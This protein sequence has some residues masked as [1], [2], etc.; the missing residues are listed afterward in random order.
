MLK[1]KKF[2]R[3]LATLSL[4]ELCGRYPVTAGVMTLLGVGGV[5]SGISP[6]SPPAI[7][8]QP[9]V[10]FT[11]SSAV[12]TITN[13]TLRPNG[14]TAGAEY[15]PSTIGN[16]VAY[17]VEGSVDP[18]ISTGSSY[19]YALGRAA[20]ANSLVVTSPGP[21]APQ[22]MVQSGIAG[23]LTPT[24]WWLSAGN[25][26]FGVATGITKGT[27]Y[28]EGYYPWT[29]TGGGCTREP[30]GYVWP[31]NTMAV[32]DPG[33]QCGYGAAA[34]SMV[35]I[36]GTG[37][38]QSTVP[39]TTCT[40]NSPFT[41]EFT[42]TASVA[43]AHGVLPGQ[44]FALTGFTPS[45]YNLTYTAIAGTAGTTLVGVNTSTGTCPGTVTGEGSAMS[46][47]GGSINLTALSTTTPFTSDNTTGITTRPG[48]HFCGVWGEYGQDSA[49]PGFQFASFTDR[50]GNALPGAP[51]VSTWPNQGTAS[52]TGYTITGAQGT[53]G[54]AL[55]VTAMISFPISAAVWNNSTSVTFTFSSNPGLWLG[56]EFTVSGSNPA[57]YNGT[58]IV[59]TGTTPNTVTVTATPLAGPL[60]NVQSLSNPGAYVGSASAVSVI[61]PGMNVFGSTG[62]HYILPFG[63]FGATGTGG[64]GTYGLSGTEGTFTFTGTT[65]G[66]STDLT[67][68]GLAATQLLAVGEAI[69]GANIQA[70]TTITGFGAS[71]GHYT[72]SLPSTGSVSG[73]V[74]AAG[75]LFSSGTPGPLNAFQGYYAVM[76]PVFSSG[77]LVTMNNR[78]QAVIGDFFS[79]IGGY[80]Q[81][82]PAQF[83]GWGGSLANLADFWGVFPTV[84]NAPS[85]AA[86]ASLC[87]KTTDFQDFATANGLAVHSIYR[88]NDPGVWA[89]SGVAQFTG[90]ISGTALTVTS[91]QTGSTSSMGV[92]TVISGN[93]ITGCPSACP[94]IASGTGSSYTLNASGGTVGPEAMTAGTYAPASPI[95]T[96]NGFSGFISG[97]TLTVTSISNTA[98]F[99]GSTTI[100]QVSFTGAIAGNV[101]TVTGT[102]TPSNSIEVGM[103]I[104]T[105]AGVPANT[106]IT[107]NGTGTGSTGTYILNNSASIGAEAM[108]GSAFT[109]TTVLQTPTNLTTIPASGAL[110]IGMLITDGGASIKGPPLLV[111]SLGPPIL[112]A[113]NYYPPIT[114]DTTM[115]GVNTTLI[116]GQYVL[117]S[118]V[119]TPI[120]IVSLGTGPSLCVG[121]TSPGA[122]GCGTY[123]VYNPASLTIGS[124][125]A[126]VA[127]TA[128]GASDGAAVAPGPALTITDPGPGLTFPVTNY[129]AGTGTLW[130]SGTYDT[131]S[132]GGT[133]ST[134][135]AQVSYTAG[136]PPISGCGACAWT[137]LAN[138]SISGGNWSGQAVS[139][140]AGGPY[141]V[142]VRAANGTSYATLPSQVKVG[143]VF[144]VWGEGQLATI[145]TG[146]NGGWA[147]STFI[148]LSGVNASGGAFYSYDTG[149]ALATNFYPAFTQMLAGDRFS[150]NGGSGEPI[151]EGASSFLQGLQ[152]ATGYPATLSD[153][154]RDG[155]GLNNFTYGNLT[156]TQTVGLG[157]GAQLTWCSTTVFCPTAGTGGALSFNAAAMT[158]SAFTGSI[159][160]SL[161]VS[162]LTVG[163]LSTGAIMPGLVLSG[164]GVTGSPTLVNCVTGCGGFNGSGSTWTLSLNEGTVALEAMRADPA[165]GAPA[166]YFNGQAIQLPITS[167]GQQL[168]KAGTFSIS[169]GGSVV[170]T[171][172]NTTVY[173]VMGGNCTGATIASSFVNYLTGDYQV[174][175]SAG[176]APPS[177]AVITASWT[178]IVSPDGSNL[179]NVF[180]NLDYTGDGTATGG[181]L[182][183]VFART[184]GGD[185]GHILGGCS[186]DA[187]TIYPMGYPSGAVGLSQEMSWFFGVK[188]PSLFPF[189]SSSIPLIAAGN[190]RGDGPTYYTS[191][192]SKLISQDG[193]CQ[194]WLSDLA[195]Q[196]TFSGTIATNVLTL[197]GAATGPM[198]EGEVIGCPTF[199]LTCAVTPG[200]Y[201][202]S[203][204]SGAWGAS[205]STYNLGGSPANVASTTAMAN[206]VY[207]Q[208][209]GPAIYAGPHHDNDVLQPP[210]GVNGSEGISVHPNMGFTGGRRAG[211]RW[212]ALIWAGL[213]TPSS[214][215]EPTLDRALADAPGCDTSALAPPCLDTGNTYAASHSA[216]LAA[217]SSTIT[218]TGGISANARPFVVGQLLTCAGCTAGRFITAIDVPPTQSTVAGQGEV[219]QT[220]HI[221]ASGT[222]GFT[223]T[224][225]VTAGCSGTAGIGSNCI[226]MAFSV[227]TTGTYG[228]AAAIATCGEGNLS[229]TVTPWYTNPVGVCSNRGIGSLVHGFR[230]GTVQAMNGGVTPNTGGTAGSP[231]DDGLDPFGGGFSQSSAFTCN[232]VDVKVVQCVKNALYTSGLVASIGQ[233]SSGATYVD[234]GD[235]ES[236]GRTASLVGN[237][238]GQPF[239]FTAGSGYTNGTYTVNGG[240][241]QTATGGTVIAPAVD[242]TVSGGAIANVYGSS[243]A[244][245]MG[246][247]VGSSCSF[248]ISAAFTASI[249]GA[250]LSVTAISSGPLASGLTIAGA[251][252]GAGVKLTVCTAGCSGNPSLTTQTWSLSSTVGTIGSESM[253]ASLAA[254]GA[255]T[256]GSVTQPPTWPVDGAYGMA[257]QNNSEDYMGDLLY[258][259]TGFPGNPLNRFFTNGQGGYFEP[260][261]PVRPFGVFL[262]AAVSG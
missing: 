163:T 83:N 195:T 99:T 254:M 248:P 167:F 156:Q 57:G 240:G 209:G 146:S 118:S 106:Y 77:T 21:G 236:T 75:T 256:G 214:A 28:N 35:S 47:S 160:T 250:V 115:V 190:W 201:I 14:G 255:G 81:A 172:T 155:Q 23:G 246:V 193:F 112:V 64:T 220:F 249:S 52:F 199:S 244:S 38:K 82:M 8:P 32:S 113:P 208:G 16:S 43:V 45:G 111:T 114:S 222:M 94:K 55:N 211:S 60:Q 166:P 152:G 238:G 228:T 227:N 247:G 53:V 22:I 153:W 194:Q 123:T 124:S 27:L 191:S 178:E 132:L 260:G 237:V 18:N 232:I 139:I 102:V 253:T 15:E 183:S 158:G 117:N 3:T 7:T 41:G 51:A 176:N 91:T 154:V 212:A 196:S 125:G 61:V 148:G 206:A 20:S 235:P 74:T 262:G 4:W 157:T 171:D 258:D 29:A 141:Y 109:P 142:S 215:S 225:V 73:T 243:A 177:G 80:S 97:N 96:L 49:T 210:G 119:T 180:N 72:M 5:L 173:S 138:S 127:F 159:A 34:P 104:L 58:Y 224:E 63:A 202:S 257:A 122:Y 165:G 181:F 39:T 70:G 67:V 149:P 79:Y 128:T 48:G 19:E 261:L 110:A 239:A 189:M 76:A 135:Q 188:I 241:C 66:I 65:T 9:S 11:Q 108:T 187:Y 105:G 68:S 231:F 126:P 116:P 24:N 251:G 93:G 129:G 170:C 204:A 134:L 182:S 218:V 217:A 136:G 33:F 26:P 140:P 13:N 245:S 168:M 198:W 234:Y 216:T 131:A 242:V 62:T 192:Q 89:D 147:N 161:G 10:T 84:G 223:G 229:G 145:T 17:Y 226:D 252:I 179:V 259:N 101:L 95:S 90:S 200:T 162:T 12:S 130:L 50:E 169:V 207:Y 103:K 69:S 44:T 203:L 120:K 71:S 205:G 46:G 98:T 197:A 56:S 1:L 219:G 233:W 184:P 100:P 221:T 85:T 133:P 31:L 185:S 54:P 40:P 164:A 92:N 25:L 2:L 36:T 121:G 213:T 107:A 137:N 78:T 144:D 175:F 174:T 143:F 150:V 151:P 186:S 230:I 30:S 42:V 37:A 59:A 6:L 87:K 86:I 88:L